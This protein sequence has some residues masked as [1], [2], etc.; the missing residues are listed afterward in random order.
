LAKSTS[1]GQKSAPIR[2]P[3]DRSKLA[4][5]ARA[6][7]DDDPVWYEEAAAATAGFDGVPAP[8]TVGVLAD[9]WR[10]GGVHELIAIAGLDPERVLHGE[11][12]W[13]YMQP[14]RMGDELTATT[15][16][17]EITTRE[18]KRGGTMRLATVETDFVNQR[19]ELALRR[20]DV[21]IEK[22]KA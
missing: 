19:G 2:C 3:L 14:L 5:L 20:R 11:I 8:P 1:H 7:H 12:S 21:L 17:G 15:A 22:G 18:G 6:F 9:H 13:E 16:L 4:E 10:E